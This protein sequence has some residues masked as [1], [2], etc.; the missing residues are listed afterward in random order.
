MKKIKY[1]IAFIL[2]GMFSCDFDEVLTEVPKDF[3]SPENSF[4]NKAQFKS[5]IANIYSTIRYHRYSRQDNWG[6]YIIFG[7]NIDLGHIAINND[8]GNEDKSDTTPKMCQTPLLVFYHTEFQ[9]GVI[10]GN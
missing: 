10:T 8:T 1:I 3:L 5:A 7:Q 4:T 2:L 9:R 6:R